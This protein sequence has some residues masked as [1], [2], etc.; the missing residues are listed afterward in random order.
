MPEMMAWN[1]TFGRDTRCLRRVRFSAV[2]LLVLLVLAPP[3]IAA[4]GTCSPDSDGE[5][6]LLFGDLHVHTA[7]SLDAYAFGTLATPREAYAFAKGQP[8]RLDNGQI[9]AIDRPLDFTAVTDHAETWEITLDLHGSPV[10][11]PPLLP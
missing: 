3:A 1:H 9:V 8:L 11:R 4:A 10:C 6:E 7:Y 2:G 5:L